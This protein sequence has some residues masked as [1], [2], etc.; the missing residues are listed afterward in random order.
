M[1]N[2]NNKGLSVVEF[3]VVFAILMVLVF[4]MMNSIMGL[5]DTNNS[6]N[7]NKNLLEYK[8]TLTKIINDDLIKRNFKSLKNCDTTNK[9]VTCTF[10]FDDDSESIFSV[11]ISEY[12]ISYNNKKYQ[13]P[14]RD[15]LEFDGI[16]TVKVE[17]NFL[18]INMPIYE[19]DKADINY[20]LNIIHPIGLS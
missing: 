12:L 3:I 16:V 10:V 19:I 8:T 13:I 17:D 4:G 9:K 11:D 14:N 1:K 2:L 7:M 18:L 15:F 20:G 5:K 6:T